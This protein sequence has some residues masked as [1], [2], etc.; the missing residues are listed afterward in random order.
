[1]KKADLQEMKKYAS[2]INLLLASPRK[3]TP[4]QVGQLMFY[5]DRLAELAMG[6][7]LPK[8]RKKK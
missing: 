4:H 1:M 3:L 8:S 2:K 5:S 7:K 6:I